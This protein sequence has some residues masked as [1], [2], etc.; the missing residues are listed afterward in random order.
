MNLIW[1]VV[2][3]WEV[4]VLE[5]YENVKANNIKNI[6]Q[7]KYCKVMKVLQIFKKF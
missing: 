6:M 5:K 7:L 1:K 2:N 3:C 4:V